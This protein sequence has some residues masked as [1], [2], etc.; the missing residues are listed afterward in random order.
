MNEKEKIVCSFL[1]F[2]FVFFW[3]FESEFVAVFLNWF[4]DAPKNERNTRLIGLTLRKLLKG[5]QSVVDA[6]PTDES[7]GQSK[8]QTLNTHQTTATVSVNAYAESRAC[9]VENN[10][11][12]CAYT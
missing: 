8:R 2:F 5:H 10:G 11:Q 9:V 3:Y 4:F 12:R 7:F 6:V 1:F